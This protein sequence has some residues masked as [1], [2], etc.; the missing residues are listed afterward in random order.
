MLAQ[1][2]A[3][4]RCLDLGSVFASPS[5]CILLQP[6]PLVSNQTDGEAG[7]QHSQKMDQEQ[8]AVLSHSSALKPET[9]HGHPT[10]GIQSSCQKNVKNR[11]AV[12]ALTHAPFPHADC[13]SRT[14]EA[15]LIRR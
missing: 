14:G 8:P 12:T 15:A 11:T 3:K 13:L 1:F 2:L 9:S 7:Q 6:Q 10:L 5:L 4:L